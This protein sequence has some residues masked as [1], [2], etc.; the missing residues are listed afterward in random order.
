MCLSLRGGRLFAFESIGHS[1]AGVHGED[2]PCAAVSTLVRTVARVLVDEPGIDVEATPPV[3]GSIRV[4]SIS[5]PEGK[6]RWLVGVTDVLVRGIE[7][8][9]R[10]YPQ[11]VDL[12]V[13]TRE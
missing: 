8:I 11:H 13:K 7:D 5:C 9:V 4:K 3:P 10:D 6:R 2:L 12:V 1:G